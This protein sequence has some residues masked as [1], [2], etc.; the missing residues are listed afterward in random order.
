MSFCVLPGL[1]GQEEGMERGMKPEPSLLNL[2][3]FSHPIPS[4]LRMQH[5]D[6]A[7]NFPELE[8]FSSHLFL[9]IPKALWERLK[10]ANNVQTSVTSHVTAKGF[11]A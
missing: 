7:G 2:Y 10:S 11:I 5:T 3:S 6:P 9:W 4:N 1:S 8:G